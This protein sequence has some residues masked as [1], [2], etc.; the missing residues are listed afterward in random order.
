MEVIWLQAKLILQLSGND[1]GSRAM[2][3]LRSDVLGDSGGHGVSVGKLSYDVT[4]STICMGN[5]FLLATNNTIRSE[6]WREGR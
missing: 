4:T 2:L 1:S 5:F 3:N 6:K